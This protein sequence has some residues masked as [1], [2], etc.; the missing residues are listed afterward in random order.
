MLLHNGGC[1][2][3]LCDLPVMTMKTDSSSAVCSNVHRRV[4]GVIQSEAMFYIASELLSSATIITTSPFRFTALIK[5][6]PLSIEPDHLR[7]DLSWNI[8]PY[9]VLAAP[10][11][12]KQRLLPLSY[13][14]ILSFFLYVTTHLFLIC[15]PRFRF[16]CPVPTALL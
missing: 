3:I 11:G 8:Q 15:T 5:I 1:T 6:P 14:P 13:H 9:D 4:A 2:A 7:I 16:C 12:H 10:Y